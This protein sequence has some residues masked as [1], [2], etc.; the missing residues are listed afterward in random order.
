MDTQS[1]DPSERERERERELTKH[2]KT[3]IFNI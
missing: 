3:A 2:N 1:A